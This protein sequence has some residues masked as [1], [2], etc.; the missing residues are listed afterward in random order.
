MGGFN[1]MQNMN[2]NMGTFDTGMGGMGM[3]SGM[4]GMGAM[5]NG[6]GGM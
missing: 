2:S 6:M 1:T 5:N 4:G 3:N